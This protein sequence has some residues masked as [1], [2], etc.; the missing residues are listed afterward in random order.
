METREEAISFFFSSPRY[1]TKESNERMFLSTRFLVLLRCQIGSIDPVRRIGGYL[2]RIGRFGAWT[3]RGKNSPWTRWDEPISGKI[4]RV[5]RFASIWITKRFTSVRLSR[6]HGNARWRFH[7]RGPN[8]LSRLFL[9]LLHSRNVVSI[10]ELAHSCGELHGND[11]SFGLSL[12]TRVS[13]SSDEQQFF[14]SPNLEFQVS[15]FH[16]FISSK[17]RRGWKLNFEERHSSANF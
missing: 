10:R 17:C 11:D 14:Q 5:L 9:E 12:V 6:R 8:S 2:L 16:F 4:S 7:G 1:R 13:H 15:F 3:R